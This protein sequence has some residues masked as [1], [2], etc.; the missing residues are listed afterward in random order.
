MN[1]NSVSKNTERFNEECYQ[2]EDLNWKAILAVDTIEK[3]IFKSSSSSTN[4]VL[5]L[6]YI[7][8]IKE[9]FTSLNNIVTELKAKN[10]LSQEYITELENYLESAKPDI[11]EIVDLLSASKNTQAMQVMYL[12]LMP[13]IDSMHVT[14][15]IISTELD[16]N[17][18]NFVAEAAKIKVM[19]IVVLLSILVISVIVSLILASYVTKSIVNPLNEISE[20]AK[21]MSVGDFHFEI[22]HSSK[23]ELGVVARDMANTV[24]K[25]NLYIG[26][27]DR[28]LDKISTDDMTASIDMEYI[29]GFASI[30]KSVEKILESLNGTFLQINEA[31][32]Q[33]SSSAE[34]VSGGAQ[35]LSQGATEQASS[36]QQLSASINEISEQVKANANNSNMV[37][38][39]TNDLV[40]EVKDGSAQMK[41]MTI[42]MVDIKQ[43]SHE[44]A[45]IIKD[46]DDIAFQTNILALNAA[47]EAARAGA[48]GKGFAVVADEVRNL[49]SKSAEAAKNTTVLIENS[50]KAVEHGSKIADRTEKSMINMVEGINH[51]VQLIDKIAEASNEQAISIMQ[52]TQGIE[53][54]SGV[55]QTNSATAE[56]SAAAS[57]EL[58]GQANML[59]NLV[60]KVKLK[61]DLQMSY[62]YDKKEE[63][64]DKE[65]EEEVIIG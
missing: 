53:Q 18:K 11:D 31:S 8:N 24:D 55:V 30:K 5:V 36:I 42:A 43:A 58:S 63:D 19:S 22:K 14:L 56:E 12:N 49:A 60:G 33:L 59:K 52:V 38:K 37:S 13:T 48:A 65:E 3:S 44:I 4:R 9:G 6:Q 47:V 21:L 39:T 40:S 7:D 28:V 20:A 62:D 61:S 57:E 34:Q 35:A 50:I 16:L 29:G 10:A 46:I 17:A 1:I 64:E 23:D 25:L 54:I 15:N 27:V 2:V 41:Q 51:S 32:E 26:D 45:K